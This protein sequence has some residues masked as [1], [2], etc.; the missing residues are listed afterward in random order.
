[1]DTRGVEVG[2]EPGVSGNL[3]WMGVVELVQALEMSRRTARVDLATSDGAAGVLFVERGAVV[4]ARFGAL[5]GSDA[6]FSMCALRAGRFCVSFAVT[7]A[8]TVAC[9]TAGLLLEAMRR[10]DEGRRAAP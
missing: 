3:S 4:H 7:P 5:S 1:M 9:S 10:T 8:R 2:E 6:F